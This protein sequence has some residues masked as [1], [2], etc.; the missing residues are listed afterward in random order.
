MSQLQAALK[1]AALEHKRTGEV[2]EAIQF[3]KLAKGFD[4]IIEA[5]K[6]GLPID[7]STI[8]QIPDEVM[9]KLQQ[10]NL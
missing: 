9:H 8:P 7:E 3:M 2:E 1:Q 4:P 10:L 6:C 5:V